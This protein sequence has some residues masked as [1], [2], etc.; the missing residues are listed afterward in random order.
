MTWDDLAKR[1]LKLPESER[2]KT[3][4]YREP[5]D[6]YAEMFPVDLYEATED[7]TDSEGVVKVVKGERFLQ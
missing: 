3:A 6:K 2:E 4:Y 5:Y 1:I 7:L